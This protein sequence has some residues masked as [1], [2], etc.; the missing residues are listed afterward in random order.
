MLRKQQNL[1]KTL[2]KHN[3]HEMCF[4][5]NSNGHKSDLLEIYFYFQFV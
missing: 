4:N 2:K 5:L 1:L 3:K